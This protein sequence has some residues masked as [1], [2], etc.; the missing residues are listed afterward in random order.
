MNG[1]YINRLVVAVIA[2]LVLMAGVRVAVEQLYPDGTENL[3]KGKITVIK[4]PAPGA[5]LANR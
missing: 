3:S 2:G 5:V 4:V 1:T